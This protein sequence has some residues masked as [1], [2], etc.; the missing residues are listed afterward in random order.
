MD[1]VSLLIVCLEWPQFRQNHIEN[2][3]NA[4]AWYIS[5]RIFTTKMHWDAVLNWQTRFQ[6]HMLKF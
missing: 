4:E 3:S 2:H 1:Y 6:L 5:F